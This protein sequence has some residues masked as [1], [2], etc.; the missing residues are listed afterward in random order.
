MLERECTQVR[1]EMADEAAR[2]RAD[3]KPRSS[4][5]LAAMLEN[6]VAK[7]KFRADLPLSVLISAVVER[8]K[9]EGRSEH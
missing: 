7:Y 8:L 3:L 9:E 1:Q 6:E 5:V 2:L 4:R